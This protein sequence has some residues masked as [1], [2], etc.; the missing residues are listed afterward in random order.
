MCK[1][2]KCISSGIKGNFFIIKQPSSNSCWATVLCMM[3]SWRNQKFTSEKMLLSS[4]PRY[5]NLF[6]YGAT[7]GIRIDEEIVLYD[8]LGLEIERQL[9]PSIKGW[10]EMIDSY[11]P[12]SITIDARP[13]FGTIHAILMLGIYGAD[14]GLDTRVVYADPAIGKINDENFLV[15]LKM[16]ESKY[17]V[18]WPIQII[19][20]KNNN[21]VQEVKK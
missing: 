3:F 8:T 14:S 17:S 5:L 7:M 1:T 20:F 15:F 11:G 4:Y 12:L 18:D 19:H 16:Y 9:N 10:S 13:P 21:A 6:K 2:E